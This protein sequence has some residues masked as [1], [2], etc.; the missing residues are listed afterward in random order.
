MDELPTKIEIGISASKRPV[1]ER[2][3]DFFDEIRFHP[4]TIYYYER[5]IEG[6]PRLSP[7][8]RSKKS[9]IQ[10][11][12]KTTSKTVIA[13][14][15]AP[16]K[17]KKKSLTAEKL[18]A[19]RNKRLKI[20]DTGPYVPAELP[21][22]LGVS[23]TLL[24]FGTIIPEPNFTKDKYVYPIGYTIRRYYH[25]LVDPTRKTN[26]I[27]KILE[28]EDDTGKLGVPIFKLYRESTPNIEFYSN[29]SSGVWIKL[30]K[31]LNEKR[32]TL[33]LKPGAALLSGIEMLGLKKHPVRQGIAHLP[34]FAEVQ[35]FLAI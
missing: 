16:A 32:K 28:A 8:P 34:N 4:K 22:Q 26:Y 13:K 18:A 35:P 33:G 2:K 14:K 24:N 10:K 6:L 29:T 12:H 30:L 5:K 31:A 21:L 9:K 15:A 1:I 27:C 3:K 11:K 20:E 25:D 7:Y 19:V 17:R 23:L